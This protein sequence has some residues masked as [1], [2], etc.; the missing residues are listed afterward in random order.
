MKKSLYTGVAAVALSTS[1][2]FAGGHLAFAP[3]DGAFSWDQMIYAAFR[4]KC[5]AR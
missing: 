3:G 1:A 2:A 4:E 5:D